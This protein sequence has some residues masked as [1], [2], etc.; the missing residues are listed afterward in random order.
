MKQDQRHLFRK[1]KTTHK[2]FERGGG[3]V[4]FANLSCEPD[5]AYSCIKPR[6]EQFW[7][8]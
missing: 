8:F 2:N 3:I 6:K 7:S 1:S 4:L 5:S